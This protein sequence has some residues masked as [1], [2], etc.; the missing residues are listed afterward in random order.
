MRTSI[1]KPLAKGLV[2]QEQSNFKTKSKKTIV[3][4]ACWGVIPIPLADWL[5]RIGGLRHE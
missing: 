3:Y 1:K 4:L 5:L 2:K